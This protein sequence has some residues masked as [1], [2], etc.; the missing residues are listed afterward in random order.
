LA[1]EQGDWTRH[2]RRGMIWL[3]TRKRKTG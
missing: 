3:T 1:G 2:V